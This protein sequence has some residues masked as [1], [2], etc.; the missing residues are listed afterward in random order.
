[1]TDS[2]FA[3]APPPPASVAIA[4]SRQHLPVRRIFCVGRN[5]A[6]HAR[7][8][9]SDPDREAPFFFSKP[10]DTLV[11]DGGVVPYPSHSSNLHFEAELVVALGSGGYRVDATRAQQMIFGYAAG[12]DMTL[13]DLQ[14]DAK[15]GGRPWDMSKGFDHS[16][17]CGALA[18]VE[19]IGH[20]GRG[21]IALWQN[22][23]LRQQADLSDL[24]WP[25]PELL[26]NLSQ[27]V[28]LAAGDLIYT[29]TPAG[30]GPVAVGD[31]L[32]VRIDGVGGLAIG[33]VADPEPIRRGAGE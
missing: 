16:A 22:G 11:P 3:F 13:R 15:K 27:H 33:I 10:A 4:G 17:P 19:E 5:Y 31:R 20:P 21:R 24:I 8:M 9:G 14:N 30:V 23:E 2:P 25:V 6:E 18:T 26:A 7:E 1:M 12:L 29:G 28:R 32:E